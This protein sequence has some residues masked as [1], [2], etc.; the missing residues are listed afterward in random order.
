VVETGQSHTDGKRASLGTEG[1]SEQDGGCAENG[2]P[3]A[4]HALLR[5]GVLDTGRADI[6]SLGDTR[7][8]AMLFRG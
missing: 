7:R 6:A 1:E 3:I 8:G 2:Q 5:V 4:T